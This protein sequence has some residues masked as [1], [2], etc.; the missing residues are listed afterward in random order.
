[1]VTP[2]ADHVSYLAGASHAGPPARS[3]AGCRGVTLAPG[4]G[5]C[6]KVGRDRVSIGGHAVL[7]LEG[8]ITV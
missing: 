2:T 5:G 8:Q 7:Y 4:T 1:M 6:M 3:I